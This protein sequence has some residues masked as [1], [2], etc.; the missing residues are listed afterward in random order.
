M[1]VCDTECTSL[2]DMITVLRS[3]LGGEIGVT[4]VVDMA[5]WWFFRQSGKFPALWDGPGIAMPSIIAS[6]YCSA[7]YQKPSEL[8]G[9]LALK[10]GT[11]GEKKTLYDHDGSTT[12]NIRPLIPP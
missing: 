7:F 3:P 11:T 2:G 9:S 5:N 10:R 8:A 6:S 1:E 12:C 4:V